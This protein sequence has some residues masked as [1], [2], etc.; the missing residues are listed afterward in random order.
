MQLR[1]LQTKIQPLPIKSPAAL[2]LACNT[3]TGGLLPVTRVWGANF[4][5]SPSE[6]RIILPAKFHWH[7][8]SHFHS[9]WDT[10]NCGQTNACSYIWTEL[11][12][13][14][15][16]GQRKGSNNPTCSLASAENAIINEQDCTQV[17]IQ[18]PHTTLKYCVV[19]KYLQLAEYFSRS[20]KQTSCCQSLQQQ[21]SV[22]S[23]ETSETWLTLA[24]CGWHLFSK[25]LQH[26]FDSKHQRWM[27]DNDSEDK[28]SHK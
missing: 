6:P 28:L 5:K 13:I 15:A 9:R 20:M 18:E 24:Q 1:M 10:R 23:D 25:L 26:K 12:R 4:L 7:W 11:L 16:R 19:I 2:H 21:S 27:Q 3:Y 22:G 17:S 14:A 8:R